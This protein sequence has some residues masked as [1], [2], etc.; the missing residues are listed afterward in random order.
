[1]P[2][3]P[4]TVPDKDPRRIHQ[5]PPTKYQW[6]SIQLNVWQ[7]WQ[8]LPSTVPATEARK[9]ATNIR[10][11]ALGYAKKHDLFVKGRTFQSGRILDLLFT[12]TRSTP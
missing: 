2:I 8:D 10:L 12:T 3:T 9:M 5:T 6:D 7:C 4:T 11:A 1:M